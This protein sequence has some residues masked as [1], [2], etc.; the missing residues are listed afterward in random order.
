MDNNFYIIIGIVAFSIA[1][2]LIILY[3]DLRRILNNQKLEV[4]S[5]IT[6][7]QDKGEEFKPIL[8]EIHT[9]DEKIEALAV[10]T[11]KN[12]QLI[13]LYTVLLEK[14]DQPQQITEQ[15]ES[16]KSDEH[17]VFSHAIRLAKEN[18]SAEKIVSICGIEH[19]EA[20]LIVR[21][22][23]PKTID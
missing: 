13:Q 23:Q 10:L 21:M 8:K 4:L 16:V 11:K 20:E 19:S 1:L 18:Q 12:H 7:E 15:K 6:R 17:S 22:H 9:L 2:I 5:A 14:L 3:L